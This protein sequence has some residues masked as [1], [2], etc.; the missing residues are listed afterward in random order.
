LFNRFEDNI[1]I[2]SFYAYPYVSPLNFRIILV[3][4]LLEFTEHFPDE[5]SCKETFKAYRLK[6]GIRFKKCG[7]TSHYWKKNRE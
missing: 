4:R 3:M 1:F 5:Q 6:V 7:G 2:S